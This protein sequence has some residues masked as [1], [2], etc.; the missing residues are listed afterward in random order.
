VRHGLFLLR[1]FLHLAEPSTVL[2]LPCFH[3]NCHAIVSE[4]S[5]TKFGMRPRS[6]V[7][8]F[9]LS[10]PIIS[11][12]FAKI[13]QGYCVQN[14]IPQDVGG[15]QKFAILAYNG[16]LSWQP[17]GFLCGKNCSQHFGGHGTGR[18]K[19]AVRYFLGDSINLNNCTITSQFL[20]TNQGHHRRI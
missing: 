18:K 4:S 20:F 3:D 15:F 14:S 17:A 1:L 6:A 9:F 5:L 11:L 2:L 7:F 16:S 13:G 12:G 10:R 19:M 8:C